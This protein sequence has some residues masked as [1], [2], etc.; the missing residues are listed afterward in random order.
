[1]KLAIVGGHGQ[2]AR[3]LGGSCAAAGDEVVGLIRR[4]EQAA[5]LRG[6]GIDPIVLDLESALQGELEAAFAGVDAVVFAAG[7]GPGSTKSRKDTVD[8]AGS[9]RCVVAA[10]SAGV[11]RFVQISS[12]GAEN[13]PQDDG[14]FSHY[15]RAKSAA[16]ASLRNSALDWVIL[17]PGRLT[18]D[19][20]TGHVQV[21]EHVERGAI[22]RADVAALIQKLLSTPELSHVTLEAVGGQDSISEALAALLRHE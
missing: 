13:P 19:P 14:I 15:L 16:E 12:M 6:L 3:I 9:D 18:D 10:E 17:R 7:A 1:M 20:P 4:P 2:I 21:A 11:A 5:H 8:R 22:P